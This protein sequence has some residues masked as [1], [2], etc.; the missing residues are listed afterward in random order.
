M[1]D[2][3]ASS[4]SPEHYQIKDP[5]NFYEGLRQKPKIYNT[6]IHLTGQQRFKQGYFVASENDYNKRYGIDYHS[7]SVRKIGNQLVKLKS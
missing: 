7:D 6:G 2:G 5:R 4:L 1:A 3:H